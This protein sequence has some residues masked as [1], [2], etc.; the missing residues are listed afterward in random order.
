MVRSSSPSDDTVAVKQALTSTCPFFLIPTAP[1]PARPPQET[2][3]L[4]M[5]ERQLAVNDMHDA[6]H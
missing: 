1:C 6:L 4:D 5:E 2:A 3:H